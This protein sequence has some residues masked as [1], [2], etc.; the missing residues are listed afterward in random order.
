MSFYNKLKW[1]LGIAMIFILIIATDLIDRNN[2][3]KV[4]NSVMTIYE[5]RLVVKGLIFDMTNILHEKEL[6]IVRNDS[7]F[8]KNK[9]GQLNNEMDLLISKFENT[10]LTKQERKSLD[11]LKDEHRT[12]V[13]K[14]K[15]LT[16]FDE[17]KLEVLKAG[18]VRLQDNLKSLSNIQL[19]EG[20]KQMS[21]SKKAVSTVELFTQIEIY[22]LVFL[23]IV[24]QLIVMYQ[25]KKSE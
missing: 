23:A 1:I 2:F 25:P 12:L 7:L 13:Q 8:Y 24:I 5:D 3:I 21:I 4:R 18:I 22:F 6:A 19:K 14:E 20:R 11:D 15:G 17:K 9:V 16:H 10:N